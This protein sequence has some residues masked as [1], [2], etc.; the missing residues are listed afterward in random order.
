[1]HEKANLKT[2]LTTPLKLLT[3]V[4]SGFIWEK[5][6]PM[7]KHYPAFMIAVE[8]F[9]TAPLLLPVNSFK[10]QRFAGVL[11]TMRISAVCD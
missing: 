5:K 4:C 10:R 7:H 9:K 1:M 2:S 11:E 3:E 6:I 8:A